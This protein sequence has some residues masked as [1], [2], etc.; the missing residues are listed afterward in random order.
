MIREFSYFLRHT[1][2]SLYHVYGVILALL[3]ILLFCA[4]LLMIAE[5]LP[6]GEALY[7]SAI[8]GLTVGYGDITPTTTVG[9]IVCVVIGMIGVVFFGIVVAV[10]TRAL[11]QTAEKKRQDWKAPS[12]DQRRTKGEDASP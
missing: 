5:R 6:F 1:L 12:R 8:T 7:L 3:I 10:A 11:A 4:V 2:E 9:R